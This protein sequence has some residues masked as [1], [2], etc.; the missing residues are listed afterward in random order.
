MSQSMD[1]LLS[2]RRAD[3]DSGTPTADVEV[4]PPADGQT[5][6]LLPA[7]VPPSATA[8]SPVAITNDEA[9]PPQFPMI[10]PKVLGG[11]PYAANYMKLARTI[12]N[13]EMVPK[14]FRGKP[15]A[16]MAA[17]M[18]GY[19]V[20]LGPMQSSNGINVIDGSAGLN[21]ETM[22]ALILSDGHLFVLQQGVDDAGEP[23][24]TVYC[25]RSD[26]P[27]EIPTAEFTWTFD[28]GRRAGLVEWWEKWTKTERGGNRKLVWNPR[29]GEERP[30]WVGSDRSELKRSSAWAN[31]GEAMCG[32]RATSEAA[33]ANFAD[34]VKGLSYT[35]EEIR[36]F[37]GGQ[38]AAQPE[39]APPSPAPATTPTAS[40]TEAD[41][42]A[43]PAPDQ[44]ISGAPADPPPTTAAGTI[45]TAPSTAPAK[46]AAG[47]K[48]AAAAKKAAPIHTANPRSLPAA[49]ESAGSSASS[50]AAAPSSTPARPSETSDSGDT[51][52]QPD[53]AGQEPPPAPA[54]PEPGDTAV[55]RERI[56]VLRISIDAQPENTRRLLQSFLVGH[57]PDLKA[58]ELSDE[59]LELAIKISDGWP[60][61]ADQYPIPPAPGTTAWE[62]FSA[63]VVK[64]GDEYEGRCQLCEWVLP[65]S[66]GNDRLPDFRRLEL[67]QSAAQSH[68]SDLYED[69]TPYC[70]GRPHQQMMADAAEDQG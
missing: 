21:A 47:T 61:S 48:K 18:Y 70:P 9:A 23:W 1:S 65:E 67:M 10:P 2:A 69:G 59:Q 32:A 4:I 53:L 12:H 39:E 7:A 44:T 38:A 13:T 62:G 58:E 28:R 22:R 3:I 55:Q 68:E 56:Q 24:A 49:T 11:L 37:D 52:V 40:S 33:R 51:S 34:V 5:G 50:S 6:E 36:E 45:P 19:E 17:F 26:W 64:V 8:G 63:F 31:Y 54:A 29:S 25:R 15:D 35:P 60:Q 30:S 27:E 42:N 14:S 41:A 57:F 43:Q 20:G 46:K 66:A 16:L